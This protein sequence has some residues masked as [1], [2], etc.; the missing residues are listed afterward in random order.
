[1]TA[2]T[3]DDENFRRLLF[4]DSQAAQNKSATSTASVDLL[5]GASDVEGTIA[6]PAAVRR[7]Q[8]GRAV[9]SGKISTR[10]SRP[11]PEQGPTVDD[12]FLGGPSGPTSIKNKQE[13]VVVFTGSVSCEN[14]FANAENEAEVKRSFACQPLVG[15]GNGIDLD[16]PVAGSSS[17]TGGSCSSSTWQPSY[18]RNDNHVSQLDLREVP[19]FGETL[20]QMRDELRIWSPFS[21]APFGG[22]SGSGRDTGGR[23]G[24]QP[25]E[26]VS[27][28][29]SNFAGGAGGSSTSSSSSGTHSHTHPSGSSIGSFLTGPCEGGFAFAT[30]T[31]GQKPDDN[32]IN[33]EDDIDFFAYHIP[34]QMRRAGAFS[35]SRMSFADFML[36]AERLLFETRLP[37]LVMKSLTKQD[38]EVLFEERW[39]VDWS[40]ERAEVRIQ[41]ITG[42][43]AL[44]FRAKISIE[45]S[46][47]SN[48]MRGGGS[49]SARETSSRALED[50]INKNLMPSNSSSMVRDVSI[51]SCRRSKISCRCECVASCGMDREAPL[52]PEVLEELL[53][54]RISEF[55]ALFS[56]IDAGVNRS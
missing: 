29:L 23:G 44:T 24:D 30:G 36:F 4:A 19:T 17:S 39:H 51:S 2:S 9:S 20:A 1:M 3:D 6:A 10:E 26:Y 55:A 41:N 33:F 52:S 46:C 8:H 49:C 12:F 45:A 15:L 13:D 50:Q 18:M 22:T 27:S 14:P 54:K 21:L 34:N 53:D 56:A 43:W 40:A 31:T 48:S 47:N 32:E 42:Q 28:M 11:T 38:M 25:G 35:F 7:D 37:L 5:G 16:I